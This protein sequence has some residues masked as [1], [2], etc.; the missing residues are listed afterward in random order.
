MLEKLYE[1]LDH[2]EYSGFVCYACHL[3]E[4]ILKEKEHGATLIRYAANLMALAR[5]DSALKAL[6]RAESVCPDPLLGH[7]FAHRGHILEAQ[8][9]FADAEAWFVKANNED[10]EDAGFLIYMASVICKQ[11]DVSR[12]EKVIRKAIACSRG[13][14]E[15]AY[16]NL[17]GYLLMQ[18]KY[19]EAH[20]SYRKA[21]AIDPTYSEAQNRLEDLNLLPWG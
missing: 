2:A 3:C 14:R 8:G 18:C 6:A 7:V 13:A 19:E 21:L 12:A 17:G 9:K 15:E 11:G 4:R 5:Y 10:P 20:E 16:Y 1:E